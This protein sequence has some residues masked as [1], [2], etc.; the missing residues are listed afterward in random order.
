MPEMVRNN[1]VQYSHEYRNQIAYKET[2]VGSL[3]LLLIMQSS[4]DLQRT[5]GNEDLWKL[6]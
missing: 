6:I 2:V 3:A 4:A 1:S 5:K